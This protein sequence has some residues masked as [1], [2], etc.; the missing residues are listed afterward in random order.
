MI[1]RG[2]RLR[3][4]ATNGLRGSNRA[5]EREAEAIHDISESICTEF[6]NE[7]LVTTLTTQSIK[8]RS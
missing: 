4:C 5:R 3:R 6:E 7:N 2:N 8:R 1:G